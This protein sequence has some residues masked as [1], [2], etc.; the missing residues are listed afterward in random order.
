MKI[1]YDASLISGQSGIERYTQELLRAM[2]RRESGDTYT[3]V[4]DRGQAA[5]LISLLG[6]QVSASIAD[7]M[8]SEYDVPKPL[9]PLLRIFRQRQLSSAVRSADVVHVLGPQKI[10]PRARKLAVTIH[11]LFPLDPAMELHSVLVRRFPARVTRQL[12]AADMV[13]T[14]S[15]YVAGTIREHFPWYTGPIRVTPLAA[16][17]VFAPTPLSEATTKI[18][19]ITKPYVIFIGRVDGRK[20]L[21]RILAAWRSLPQALRSEADLVLLIPGSDHAI[22]SLRADHSETF[23]DPSVRLCSNV[24]L[25]QMVELLSAAR[26]LVFTTLGEGFGLPVIEAMQCGCPVITSDC[27]ALPEVGGSAALYADP[28]NVEAIAEQIRRCLTDDELVERK[29]HEGLSHAQSFSWDKT[30]AVTHEAYQQ[31]VG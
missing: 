3:I 17:A 7:V 10:V 11:D 28:R 25:G 21:R 15:T 2:L 24:P 1:A 27:T 18:Y 20:N 29:R 23:A 30:A 9:R 12:Q 16:D 19:G 22:A 5:T 31:I 14:P 4:G 8:M 13:M 26:A 6:N